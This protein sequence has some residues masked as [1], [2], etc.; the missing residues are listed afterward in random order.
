[1]KIDDGFAD[2]PKIAAVGA[3]GAWLQIQALCYAN[4]NLTDGFIPHGIARSFVFRGTERVD[5]QQVAWQLGETSGNQG[6]DATECDWIAVMIDAGLWD[7]VDGGYVIHNYEQYQPLKSQVLSEREKS[8]VRQGRATSRRE[9]RQHHAVTHGVSDAVSDAVNSGAPVPVPVPVELH[10]SVC[11]STARAPEVSADAALDG[12]YPNPVPWPACWPEGFDPLTRPLLAETARVHSPKCTDVAKAFGKF[13][14]WALSEGVRTA[15]WDQR[16]ARWA[17]EHD[18]RAC[19]CG[20]GAATGRRGP[21]TDAEAIASAQRGADLVFGRKRRP[22][23][24]AN[25]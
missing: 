15:R 20:A 12:M 18:Q 24:V 25:G 6:R 13:R 23:E 14:A 11:S 8:R 3:I 16:W 19:P 22:A 1:M 10:T 17:M 5:D 9:S 7:P 21:A 4:R 2:H